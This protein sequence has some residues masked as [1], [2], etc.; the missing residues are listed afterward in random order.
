M[1][2]LTIATPTL[3]ALGIMIVRVTIVF[4]GKASPGTD[5]NVMQNNL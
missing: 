1:E 4:V 2:S 3:N 5:Y